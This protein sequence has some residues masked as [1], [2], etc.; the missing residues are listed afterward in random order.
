LPK[1]TKK[2]RI[3]SVNRFTLL[4]KGRLERRKHWV[5]RMWHVPQRPGTDDRLVEESGRFSEPFGEIG[6]GI[7]EIGQTCDKLTSKSQ[8]HRN[9]IVGDHLAHP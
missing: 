4:Q 9:F 3:K 5:L 8:I 2:Y 7:R 1:F 6:R